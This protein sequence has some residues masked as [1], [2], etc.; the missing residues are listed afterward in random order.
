VDVVEGENI[1]TLGIEVPQGTGYGLKVNTQNHRFWRDKNLTVNSPYN[2]PYIIDGVA[3]ITG[4]NVNNVDERDNYYYYFYDW[5]VS[6][7]EF[8]CEGAREEVLVTLIGVDE[9]QS[10]AN[11]TVY[12]VPTSEALTIS[13]ATAAV[14]SLQFNVYNA[15]GQIVMS[16]NV[17]SSIG[18]SQVEWNVSGLAQGVY[19]L[20]ITNGGAR[21]T[22]KFVKQ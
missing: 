8:S 5:T 6:T 16:Q 20:E 10:V 18:T 14:E 22:S 12:P 3:T 17:K 15:V 4:T 11:L 19:Q 1:L 13:F 21:T 7:P 2:F 9:L